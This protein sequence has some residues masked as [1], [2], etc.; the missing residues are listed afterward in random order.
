[1]PRVSRGASRRKAS[2]VTN[3]GTLIANRLAPVMERSKPFKDRCLNYTIRNKEDQLIPFRWNTT[4]EVYWEQREHAKKVLLLKYRQGGFTTFEMADTYDRFKSHPE[5]QQV[6]IADTEAKAGIIFRII[7]RFY[8]YD[9]HPPAMLR[10]PN[11]VHWESQDKALLYIETAGARGA[12]SRGATLTAAK[13]T[14]VSRWPGSFASIE[15]KVLGLTEAAKKGVIIMETT[16]NG[17]DAWF[18]PTWDDPKD[19]KRIFLP[20]FLDPQYQMTVE[21]QNAWLM[22]L[23]EEARERFEERRGPIGSHEAIL[24]TLTEDEAGL[25]ESVDLTLEQVA[26][27][28]ATYHMLGKM[29]LQEYPEDPATAFIV[30]GTTLFDVED[31]N[32]ALA[33]ALKPVHVIKSDTMHIERFI[34][35]PAPGRRYY[36]AGDVAEGLEGGDRCAYSVRDD[37]GI[38]VE[39]GWIRESPEQFA[40]RL[41][42]VGRYYNLA[43]LAPEVNGLG[44][45]TMNELLNHYLYP[46]L[47]KEMEWNGNRWVLTGRHGWMTTGANR[48]TMIADMREDFSVNM[49]LRVNSR[50]QLAEMKS[51][52]LNKTRYEGYP[53]DD[54]FMADCICNQMRRLLIV[55]QIFNL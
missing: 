34:P 52:V 33:S 9:A 31:I 54:V 47:W 32:A 27:R 37:L 46:N 23:S 8:E 28:R 29:F 43:L 18:K 38:Q 22:T 50:P 53:H 20:W 10:G 45:S 1:M 16:P 48:A 26:W 7:Q 40:C 2:P 15:D 55:P 13:C 3:L 24:D 4:Q 42:G 35:A 30:S 44:R 5:S 17:E 51:I 6:F 12:G 36:V 25:M 21:Q 19:W 11:S 14:E 39:A 41:N 49:S